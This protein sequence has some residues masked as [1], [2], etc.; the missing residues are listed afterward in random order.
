MILREWEQIPEWLKNAATR[1]YYDT[2]R[3]RKF[4]LFLK[5]VFDFIVAG[6][7]LVLLSPALIL[8]AILVKATSKGPVLYKQERLTTYGRK[9]KIF[10]FRT[11]IENADKLGSLV[12]LD[13]DSRVT[14]V[15]RFLRKVRLDEIPQLFNVLLGQMSFVGTRPEVQKY[16]DAYSEEMLATLLMPAGITSLACISFKDEEK[17]LDSRESVEEKYIHEILPDKMRYNLEYIEKFNIFYDMKLMLDTALA[18]LK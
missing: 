5:R 2:L 18:V 14:K 13:N 10:K 1:R 17:Y 6:I 4:D 7:L 11:M 9:F 15:G 12:T 16:V 3:R 8:T